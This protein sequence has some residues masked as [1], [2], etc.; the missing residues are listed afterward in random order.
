LDEIIKNIPATHTWNFNKTNLSSNPG[1]KTILIKQGLKHPEKIRNPSK[2]PIS[3]IFS[4]NT[5]GTL[6]PSYVV[7]KTSHNVHYLD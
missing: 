1:Q 4:I 7:Y 3:L 5:T 6:L 2:T